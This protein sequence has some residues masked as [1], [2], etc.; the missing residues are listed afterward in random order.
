MSLQRQ[1]RQRRRTRITSSRS[2]Y[3]WEVLDARTLR[4]FLRELLTVA[5]YFMAA[6]RLSVWITAQEKRPTRSFPRC[7][8]TL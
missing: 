6:P 4:L 1:D 3:L 2:G 8:I 5:E 7:F